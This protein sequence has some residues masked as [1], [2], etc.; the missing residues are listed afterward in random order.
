M[1]AYRVNEGVRLVDSSAEAH[2]ACFLLA[3]EVQGVQVELGSHLQAEVVVNIEDIGMG[4]GTAEE[5]L[6]V[7]VAVELVAHDTVGAWFQLAEQME[8]SKDPLVKLG[9]RE[10]VQ[11][12]G[13]MVSVNVVNGLETAMEV[14]FEVLEVEA[15]HLEQE[16]R[17]VLEVGKGS[18]LDAVTEW[19][20]AG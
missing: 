3:A 2:M 15:V 13:L 19:L 20:L 10:L 16:G 8:R 11:Q 18:G 4:I 7:P 6:E 5:V 17:E 9:L 12:T 14:G 1:V